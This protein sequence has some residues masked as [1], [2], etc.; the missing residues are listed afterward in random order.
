VQRLAQFTFQ[1]TYECLGFSELMCNRA[2]QSRGQICFCYTCEEYAQALS[3][4]CQ[5][6]GG[7]LTNVLELLSWS[8]A[9]QL[10]KLSQ[11]LW[12]WQI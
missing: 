6:L 8:G 7:S 4:L 1:E 12:Y 3:K 9:E 5:T 11:L 10:W 2:T